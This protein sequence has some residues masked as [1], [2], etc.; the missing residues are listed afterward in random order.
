LAIKQPTLPSTKKSSDHHS[1]YQGYYNTQ[2][3]VLPVSQSETGGEEINF[4]GSL[5]EDLD[6]VHVQILKV[7]VKKFQ[8]LYPTTT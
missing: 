3:N 2:P 5:N 4:G 7:L 6:K 1:I 8:R